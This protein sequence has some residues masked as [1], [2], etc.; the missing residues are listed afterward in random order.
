MSKRRTC[1]KAFKEQAVALSMQ[2]GGEVRPAC[3]TPLATLVC[4]RHFF[5]RCQAIQKTLY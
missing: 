3:H 2:E 1:D 5:H 4:A